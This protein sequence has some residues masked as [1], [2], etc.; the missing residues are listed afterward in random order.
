MQVYK[1]IFNIS[2]NFSKITKAIS[3]TNLHLCYQIGLA[4][5]TYLLLN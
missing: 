5:M 2:V 1:K 4:N 3:T